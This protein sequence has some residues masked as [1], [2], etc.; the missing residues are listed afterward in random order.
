M[1]IIITETTTII[2]KSKTHSTTKKQE[3]KQISAID[4]LNQTKLK[5]GFWIKNNNKAKTMN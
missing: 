2:T 1:I 4:E 3:Q 5:L